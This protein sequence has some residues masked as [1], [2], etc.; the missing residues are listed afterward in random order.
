[1]G[2]KPSGE[3]TGL[4]KTG[5]EKSG[6]GGGERPVGKGQEE[7]TGNGPDDMRIIATIKWFLDCF[8]L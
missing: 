6:G 1:M 4:E 3:R 2:K 7:C 5:M 8:V